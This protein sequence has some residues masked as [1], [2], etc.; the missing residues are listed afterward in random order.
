MVLKIGIPTLVMEL[1]LNITPCS[2]SSFVLL[3]VTR[4]FIFCSLE[5]YR[6]F[7]KQ[8]GNYQPKFVFLFQSLRDFGIVEV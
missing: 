5:Y 7:F 2:Q 3:R 6:Q 8:E 1:L 4:D